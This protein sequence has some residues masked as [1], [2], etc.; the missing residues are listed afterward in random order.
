MFA[1]APWMWGVGVVAAA[2]IGITA[3]EVTRPKPPS[4]SAATTGPVIWIPA[5]S[6][7]KGSRFAMAIAYPD[8]TAA[9]AQGLSQSVT[10]GTITNEYNTLVAQLKAQMG[11]AVS[12]PG[13]P[14]PPGWPVKDTL[15]TNAARI[16]GTN[17]GAGSLNADGSFSVTGTPT[18]VLV[19]TPQ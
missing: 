8:L 14:P 12:L 16:L 1:I 9:A 3:Y 13:S 11:A 7:P 4:S 15:G 6:V 17:N 5:V 2:G 18:T 10:A 19:W